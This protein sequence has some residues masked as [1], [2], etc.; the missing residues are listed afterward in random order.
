MNL[1]NKWMSSNTEMHWQ[2]KCKLLSKT[3][4]TFPE[5]YMRHLGHFIKFTYLK[6]VC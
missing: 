4:A 3:I 1:I 5:F 6:R 2:L